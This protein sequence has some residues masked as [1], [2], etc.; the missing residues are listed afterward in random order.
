M[1]SQFEFDPYEAAKRIEQRRCMQMVAK[2]MKAC[3]VSQVD[4]SNISLSLDE[5]IAVEEHVGFLRIKGLF[6]LEAKP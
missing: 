1:S 6:Q 2:V 5:A 4:I 3:G